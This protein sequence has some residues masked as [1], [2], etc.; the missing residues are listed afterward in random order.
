MQVSR[1]TRKTRLGAT[2]RPRASLGFD[3]RHRFGCGYRLTAVL[4]VCPRQRR[5]ELEADD[6]PFD[7]RGRIHGISVRNAVDRH[8]RQ[9]SA[10]RP[11]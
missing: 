2:Q 10:P 7:D 4:P 6:F 3:E 9:E 1:T 11:E 8:K 5:G